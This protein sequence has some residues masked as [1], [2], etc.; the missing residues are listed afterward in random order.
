MSTD[1]SRAG[2]RARARAVIVVRNGVTHDARVLREARTMRDRGLDPIVVGVTTARDAQRR[3]IE[4]GTDVIRLSLAGRWPGP[5]RPRAKPTAAASPTP[6]PAAPTPPGPARP[7]LTGPSRSA[8]R[9][10]LRSL[11]FLRQACTLV[12]RL[13]PAIVH[14][15]DHNTMWVGVV[16][17]LLLGSRVIY[18]SHELWPDRNGRPEWRPGLIAAEAL[19]VRVADQVITTSPGYADVLA[20]RYRI[21]APA[22]VRNV[23]AVSA[24]PTASRLDPPVAVYVG[25]LLRGRGLEQAIDALALVPDLQLRILGP[26]ADGYRAELADRAR[27]RGVAARVD[28]ALPVAPTRVV[29]ALAGATMGLALIQPVCLSYE[30]TLPNKLFEFAAAGLPMIVSDL[31]VMAAT[32]AEWG[33]GVTAPPDEARAIAAAMT[34]LRDPGRHAACVEGAHA[35]SRSITR[36]GEQQRLGEL[37]ARLSDAS[38]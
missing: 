24:T 19:F 34:E 30:L 2:A 20:R 36:D 31:P 18:D 28:I 17:K 3:S 38:R 12:L 15:N 5:R 4:D 32:V 29:E 11:E 21:P 37:Y 8:V 25:G 16:A 14:C 9:R 7:S 26:G 33:C 27:R 13:R 10:S 6:A 35:L 22:L 1:A 23:P